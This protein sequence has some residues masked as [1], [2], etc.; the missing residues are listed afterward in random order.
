MTCR[1]S[2]PVAT[3]AAGVVIARKAEVVD[4]D[5]G[6]HSINSSATVG[7]HALIQHI[8]PFLTPEIA[9]R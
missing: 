7:A 4:A 1:Q 9:N 8:T 6:P 3:V 5:G 2:S